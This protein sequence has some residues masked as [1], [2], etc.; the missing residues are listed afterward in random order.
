M[1]R[2]LALLLLLMLFLAY[3]PAA[4]SPAG[5]LL[6]RLLKAQQT[7]TSVSGRFTQRNLRADDP[8]G[9]ASLHEAT[10]ALQAPDKYNLVYTKPGDDEWRL[11]YC[12]DG[13]VRK[14][15]TQMFAGQEPDVVASP[16]KG[17]GG[18]GAG[19]VD[20]GRYISAFLRFD[21]VAVNKDF[22]VAIATAGEGYRLDLLPREAELARQVQSISVDLDANF[23]TRGIRFDDPQGNR[24]VVNVTKA[25]YNDGIPPGTFTHADGK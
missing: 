20:I 18:T 16:V 10:F 25:V 2:A 4:D 23:Q 11:R 14:E 24:I 17:D 3:V 5:D 1:T 21:P 12:S 22:I 9:T 6:T 7:I 15:V 19:G 8:E 13:V